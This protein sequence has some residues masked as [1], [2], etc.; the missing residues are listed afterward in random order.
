M[1][2]VLVRGV[3]IRRRD[4]IVPLSALLVGG[5]MSIHS[6]VD[7]SL[8]IPAVAIFTF[9]LIGLGMA[10]SNPSVVV[11]PQSTNLD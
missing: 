1:A 10:Q 6:L 9:T 5:M 11:R 4:R 3:R 2:A 8:Q 7:F